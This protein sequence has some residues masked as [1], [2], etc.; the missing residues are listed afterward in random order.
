[1]FSKAK[2]SQTRIIN[3]VLNSFCSKV[4]QRVNFPKS[5]LLVSRNVRHQ[6]GCTLNN[7]LGIPM[8]PQLGKHLGVPFIQSRISN[9]I[10]TE[11]LER[12]Q[13]KLQGWKT[14]VLSIEARVTL[15]K[16]VISAIPTYVMQTA[17]RPK[18]LYAN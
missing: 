16:V 17:S 15:A 14:R 2:V 13:N 5:S 12:V 3:K 9:S 8:T 18:G 7:M 10:Y 6:L 4:G 11:V 1:M